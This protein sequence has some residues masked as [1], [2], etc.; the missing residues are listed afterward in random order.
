MF[1]KIRCRCGKKI[2]AGFSYCPFCG[3]ELGN[4]SAG[5]APQRREPDNLFDAL[6]EQM[7]FM[8][9]FPF[10]KLVKQ[11]ESQLR[12]IDKEMASEDKQTK[13]QNMPISQGISISISSSENG[14]PVIKVKQFGPEGKQIGTNES[15]KKEMKEMQKDQ[16]KLKGLGKDHQEKLKKF[17]KLPRHEPETNV[18]RLSD[19]IVY[20]ILLPGVKDAKNIMITRLQNSIEIKAFTK[21]RAYFKLIPLGLPIQRQYL[22]GEK[23]VLELKP[24]I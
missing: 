22:D 2:D 1:K 21:D 24:Q 6:D 19:R 14:A 13:M 9:R 11:I 17:A 3:S 15:E 20:E 10:K 4:E 16:Q 7:P 5:R 23:L 8:L 18:R 12:E